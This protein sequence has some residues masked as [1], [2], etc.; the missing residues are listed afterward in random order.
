MRVI[1]VVVLA[2]LVLAA[3][4]QTGRDATT[5][6]ATTTEAR[7]VTTTSEEATPSEDGQTIGVDEIPQE[8]IDVFAAYL[9]ALEPVIEGVDFNQATQAEFEAISVELEGPTDEFTAASEA[10]G[11]DELNL[12]VSD[13]EAFQL[14][15]DLA[16]REAPGTVA[17]FEWIRDF[18][19]SMEEG[20]TGS[21]ATGDCETDIETMQAIVDDGGT[22]NDLTLQ[23]MGNVGGLVASISTNC[24]GERS[25][26]FFSK[27][28]VAAYLASGG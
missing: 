4:G 25:S 13:E 16:E 8:C 20:G 18:S 26:E 22:I 2:A 9:R 19:A 27:E 5:T 24:S 11:C 17:Y 15:I 21:L 1:R 28:D 7:D 23:E 3:C 12:D 10:A 14:M 6:G